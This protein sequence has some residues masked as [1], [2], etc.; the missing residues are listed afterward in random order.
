MGTAL[1]RAVDWAPAPRGGSSID[2]STESY[3]SL[4]SFR[5]DGRE[6]RT[7]V[8][9]AGAEGR[10]Y[11]FSEGSAGKVKRIRNHGRVRLAACN[12]RGVVSGEW[13]EGR[14]RVVREP[15]IVERAYRA[16][17]RKY[18]WQMKVADFFSRLSGRY[19]KRAILEI[20]I[21]PAD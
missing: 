6:V 12:L 21:A 18:G 5:R 7:P 20:E 17:H 8:W 9:I 16:L 2:P 14:A 3:V 19:A 11:V 13:L 4:A 10:L 15:E 1:R